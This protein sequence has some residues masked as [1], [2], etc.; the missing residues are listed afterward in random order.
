MLTL[1]QLVFSTQAVYYTAELS[2]FLTSPIRTQKEREKVTAANCVA[3]RYARVFGRHDRKRH[4]E[5][6]KND[7]E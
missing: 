3:S 1:I 2:A 6:N 4:I 7:L 5:D